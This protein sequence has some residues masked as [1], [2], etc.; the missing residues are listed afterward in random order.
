MSYDNFLNNL[1]AS[2][3]DSSNEDAFEEYLLD[4]YYVLGEHDGSPV[5]HDGEE[6]FKVDGGVWIS[7]PEG[8][9]WEYSK[10]ELDSLE[11][12][13]MIIKINGEKDD[14]DNK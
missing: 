9:Y 8:P 4:A 1:T 2:A 10:E 11:L 3:F 12:I 7:D 6:A 5:Y 14:S 13:K